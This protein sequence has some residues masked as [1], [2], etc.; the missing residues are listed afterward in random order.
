MARRLHVSRSTAGTARWLRSAAG[1][2][3]L[4][5]LTACVDARTSGLPDEYLGRWYYMGSSGGIAGDGMGDEVNGY[6]VIQSDNTIDHHE[7]DGTPVATTEFTVGRGPTIFSTEDQWVLNPESMVPE[8]IMVSE[9]GRTM[10]LS[11]NVYDG[12]GRAYARSR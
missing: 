11:E 10:S 2:L 5:S 12:F 3:A 7:E 8:V 6:I 4:A 9:D 1:G